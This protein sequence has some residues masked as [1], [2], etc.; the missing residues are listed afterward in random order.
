MTEYHEQHYKGMLKEYEA[1]VESLRQEKENFIKANPDFPKD[2]I[3]IMF[4]NVIAP[5]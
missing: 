4:L 1:K 2:L 3:E 5:P